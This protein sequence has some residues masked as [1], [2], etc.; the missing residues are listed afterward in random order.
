MNQPNEIK[1][2]QW[3][4][5]LLR[6]F[7]KK[8]YLEEIEGDMEELF[9]DNIEH[10]SSGRAKMIYTWE[11]LKLF[12]PSLLKHIELTPTSIQ[13]SMFKNYFKASLRGLMKTPLN[14]FINIFGLSMAIG[15]CIFGY[16]FAHWTFSTDQFHKNKNEVFLA[17]FLANRDGT[18]QQYGKTPRP[19][20]KMLNVDFTHIK[21]VCRVED[22][23]V[24]L[25]YEDKVFRERVRVTDPEFLDMFT[26]PLKWGIAGSL[27]DVNSIILSE[28]MSIKYFGE[29]NPIGRSILVKFDDKRSKSFKITGVAETFPKSRTIDFSFLINF[30]NL[31]LFDP[32]YDVQDW[33]SLVNATLIQV[34][35]PSEI[36]A[37]EQGMDKYRVLQNAVAEK[38]WSISSFI[39]EPLATLHERSG[40]IKDDISRSSEDNYTSVIFLSLIGLFMLVLACFNYI[41]IAIVSAARRLKEIGIRKTAGATRLTIIVQFLSENIVMTF[42][43]LIVGIIFAVTFFIPGFEQ[44]WHFNMGFTLNDATLWIYLPSILL[45]TA[46]ASGMYPALYISKFEVVNILK[47][48]VRIGKK[49]PLTKLLL[50]I[51]LVLACI[52]ITSAAMFTQNTAYLANRSWGYNQESALYAEVPDLAAFE[53]LNAVMTQDPNI[54]SI[55]GSSHHIGRTNATAVV[56]LPDRQYEVDQ[57]SVDANY[58]NTM[59][60]HLQQGRLFKNDYESD[61]QTV[62]VNEVFAQS[63]TS[64]AKASTGKLLGQIFKIDNVQYEIIGVVSDFHNH[65]FSKK[66]NPTIFRAADRED[67]RYLSMRVRPGSEKQTY[68]SLQAQWAKLFPETPFQ[69]GYQEDVW[70]N[71][72]EAIGIHA[73]VWKV[74]CFIA[75]SLAGLGL[76]GLMT[77]NV[78]GRVKE[79]SIRKVLGAGIKNIATLITQQYMILFAAALIVGAPISYILIKFFIEWAYIYHM[80]IDFSGVAIAVAILI[81]VLLTTASTQVTKVLKAN[82]VD[83][84]KTE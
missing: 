36:T 72:F 34:D 55:S 26:F 46:I 48:S 40:H 4:V 82:P 16:A 80:P 11:M 13:Y 21:K 17:T 67:Y 14:S 10:S 19:L 76:Y 41:N 30:E 62:V 79:F 43:A 24:V 2:P 29:E 64:D 23:N 25:K 52:F 69:G 83:G 1:P 60:L 18:L 59:G 37:I 9:R 75:V 78:A 45:V 39:F 6:F 33:G 70:G 58:F 3:P 63:L 65:S 47:G 61:K 5:K 49:N 12:R 7:V 51:Q 73:T 57:L 68:K 66:V 84:L 81:L 32:G 27:A 8:N 44:M 74:I 54:L 28:E 53:Q 56:H 31:R 22:R 77:L 71:Y 35:D 38:D 20:G 50:G 15:I 42:F